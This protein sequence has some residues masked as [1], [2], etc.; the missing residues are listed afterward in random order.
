MHRLL[1]DQAH[2]HGCRE[3]VDDVALVHHLADDRRREDRV[4]HEV[5]VRAVAQVGDIGQRA[6]RNVVQREDLPARAEEVLRQVGADEPG[7]TGN[8]R[9]APAGGFLRH[10]A[11]SVHRL[12][13][14]SPTFG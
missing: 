1:D 4:D 13:A 8:E 12:Q 3:V 2:S 11:G 10:L 14:R 7:S 9:S 6:C 5:V